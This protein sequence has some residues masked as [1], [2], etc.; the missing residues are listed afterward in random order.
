MKMKVNIHLLENGKHPQKQTSGSSG[1]DLFAAQKCVLEPG[2]VQVIKLGFIIEIPLG[3]E[4]QIRSR[5]GLAMKNQLFV[6]NSPGTIDSDYRQEVGCLLMNLGNNSFEIEMH[7]RI[8]QMIFAKVE[9]VE[10]E[11][12]DTFLKDEAEGSRTSGWGSTGV[13]G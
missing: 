3:Y 11:N 8:A 2:K 6:L 13:L 12:V 1:Y 7:M 4:A 5:S 10:F 9:S